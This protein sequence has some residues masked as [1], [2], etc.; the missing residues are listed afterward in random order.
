MTADG[1]TLQRSLLAVLSAPTPAALEEFHAALLA[2]GTPQV[3]RVWSVLDQF[4]HFL[5]ELAAKT[6][7]RE[8]SHFASLLDIGAVGGV[9]VQ[10]L[11]SAAGK[12][13]W[14]QRLLA[15]GLSESLMVLAARQYVK[16]W[17][18]ETES[19]LAQARWNVYRELW[20]IS[21]TA[22]PELAAA[23]RRQLIDNLL[24]PLRDDS[25]SAAARALLIAR[26]YQLL[27]VVYV[28]Q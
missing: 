22:R 10:N 2:T 24:A 8:Y 19:L 14:W 3:D 15:G 27:L 21:A 9:A 28:Q 18:E 5:N 20:H 16:A 13:N 26:L 17:E 1:D 23:Q 7:A 25:A 6:T 11:I 4:F 12:E